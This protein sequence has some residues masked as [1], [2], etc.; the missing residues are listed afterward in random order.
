M[1]VFRYV[2]GWSVHE[3][4]SDVLDLDPSEVKSI[5]FVFCMLHL[6]ILVLGLI[7]FTFRTELLQSHLKLG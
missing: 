3:F 1:L 5:F 6:E 7:V 4:G 2:L